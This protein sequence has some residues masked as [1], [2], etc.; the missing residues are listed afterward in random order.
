MQ[1]RGLHGEAA[2]DTAHTGPRLVRAGAGYL[3]ARMSHSAL[4]RPGYT[5]PF[6][7]VV[8]GSM[9][10]IAVSAVIQRVHVSPA[11]ASA[12]AV[13]AVAPLLVYFVCDPRWLAVV[14]G[15]CGWVA[16]ALFLV[17][18]GPVR[19]DPAPLLLAVTVAVVSTLSGRLG[20][21]LAAGAATILLVGA[22]A[23]H[24]LDAVALYL[25]FIAIAFLVGILLRLQQQVIVHQRDA[26]DA[27]A[28]RA[29]ADE[30][31]RIAREVHDVVGHSLSVVALQVTGVR[32]IL[33]QDRDLDEAIG[34][35]RD[36]E[37]LTT[38]AMSDIRCTITLLDDAP[39][40]GRPQP[41]LDD[42]PGLIDDFTRAGLSVRRTLRVRPSAVSAAT[43]LEVYRIVQES[44]SNV[45]K[46]APRAATSVAVAASPSSLTIRVANDV[47]PGTAGRGRGP[48]RGLPGMRQR[49]A[50]L[51]GAIDIGVRAHQWVVDADIPLP[52]YGGD[53][54]E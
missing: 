15:V 33:E 45:A 1:R 32:H 12:A 30:R 22:S 8:D 4:T 5:W 35:L 46:H 21:A 16:T 40:T 39:S 24:R 29:V 52:N 23:T 6:I 48:G 53:D 17:P 43:G 25:T 20:G 19:A 38:Q 9:V 36:I 18:A 37:Q 7:V 49:V 26:Q 10:V 13:V 34:A 11:S 31:H 27:L 2:R 14:V 41:G 50:L 51:G 47:P 28:D 54:D 42:L 44:L 3:R